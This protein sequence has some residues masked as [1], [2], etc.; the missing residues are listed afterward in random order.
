MVE[1]IEERLL[2][3][4]DDAEIAA[5]VNAAF[6][7][8]FGGRSHFQQRHHL[9]LVLREEGRIVAHAALLFRAIAV[10]GEVIDIAGLAEVATDPAFRGRGLASR[11]VEAAI[12]EARRSLAEFFLLFGSAKLYAAQGLVAVNNPL[13]WVDLGGGASG[14]VKQGAGE[15]LMVLELGDRGWDATAPVDLLGHKF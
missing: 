12:A 2:G 3:A 4:A 11:V 8:E 6:G 9:R 14:P 5:L 7:P 15:G 10:G 13:T 1:R